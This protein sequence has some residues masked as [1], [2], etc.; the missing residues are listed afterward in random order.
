MLSDQIN[1]HQVNNY[2]R[3]YD[4]TVLLINVLILLIKIFSGL[5]LVFEYNNKKLIALRFPRICLE[6]S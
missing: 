3:T 4:V 1:I 5:C 2:Y 6:T